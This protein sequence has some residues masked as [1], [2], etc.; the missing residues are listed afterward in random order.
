[1]DTA[2]VAI[3]SRNKR[4]LHTSD[5]FLFFPDNQFYKRNVFLH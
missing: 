2:V 1:M 5:V 3:S 4:F